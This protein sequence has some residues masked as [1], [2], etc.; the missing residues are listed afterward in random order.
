M[1]SRW[2]SRECKCAVPPTSP[3]LMLPGWVDCA[4]CTLFTVYCLTPLYRKD[5]SVNTD[6]TSG[7]PRR[8]YGRRGTGPS[9]APSAPHWSTTCHSR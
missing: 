5:C 7:S 6:V 8:Y 9:T 4:H 2:S 3:A 1:L